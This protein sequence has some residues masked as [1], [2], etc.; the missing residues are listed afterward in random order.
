ML[1]TASQLF[2]RL[3][4]TLRRHRLMRAWIRLTGEPNLQLVRIRDQSFGY[5]DMSDGFLRLIVIDGDFE[6]DFFRIADCLLAHGG[7]FLDVGANHGLFSFGLA[8]RQGAV[9]DF[10]L[11]ERGT[12]FSVASIEQATPLIGSCACN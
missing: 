1:P 9:I 5:A 12:G 8:G 7:T 3:P 6:Q 11:F 10:H 4:R 2:E